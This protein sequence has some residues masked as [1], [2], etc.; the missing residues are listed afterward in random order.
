MDISGSQSNFL[1]NEENTDAL[2]TLDK[3]ERQLQ[4]KY[5]ILETQEKIKLFST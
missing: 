2:K 4:V 1:L 5:L 3:Y